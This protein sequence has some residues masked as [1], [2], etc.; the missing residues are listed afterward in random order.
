VDGKVYTL[1]EEKRGYNGQGD[2][3]LQQATND[4]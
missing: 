4:T 1:P 3:A 2:F